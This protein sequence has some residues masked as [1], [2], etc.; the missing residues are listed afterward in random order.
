MY[1]VFSRPA[2]QDRSCRVSPSDSAMLR[3]STLFALLALLP[4]STRG[5]QAPAVPDSIAHPI[6]AG[7]GV[8]I[9]PPAYLRTVAE[10]G[11]FT[12]GETAELDR[13]DG[14]LRQANAP[15]GQAWYAPDLD[16]D[17]RRVILHDLR[18]NYQE[19]W[20]GV[21]DLIGQERADVFINPAPEPRD[22]SSGEVRCLRRSILGILSLH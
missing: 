17:G 15:L 7:C 6:V 16:R 5:Q 19:W 1:V 4:A 22:R 10:P 12:P 3:A 18:A 14:K 11:T 2:H 9:D 21:V 13:L 20:S 8:R